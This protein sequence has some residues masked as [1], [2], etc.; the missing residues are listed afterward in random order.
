MSIPVTIA[1]LPD[2]MSAHIGWCYLL[3]VTEQ[4]HPRVVAVTTTWS[5]DGVSLRVQVG[6]GTATNLGSRPTLTLVWPPLD[7]AGMSLIVDGVA[8]V[9]DLTVTIQPTSAVLHRSAMTP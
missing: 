8:V 7:P 9:N 1:Q 3:S 2:A 4:G 5:A 6:K